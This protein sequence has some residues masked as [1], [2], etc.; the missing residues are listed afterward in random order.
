MPGGDLALSPGTPGH[1]W[2]RG[3]WGHLPD[4]PWA[5]AARMSRIRSEKG[6]KGFGILGGGLG[7]VWILLLKVSFCA[8]LLSCPH[9]APRT[10]GAFI[11]PERTKWHQAPWQPGSCHPWE[12]V[13]HLWLLSPLRGG[14]TPLAQAPAPHS[15]QWPPPPG[16]KDRHVPV[17]RTGDHPGGWREGQTGGWVGAQ[18]EKQMG[19]GQ[20]STHP[21][22]FPLALLAGLGQIP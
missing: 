11:G 14:T 22:W 3:S 2:Y 17:P 6:W 1:R 20:R 9:S 12:V 18:V 15:T 4:C 5:V 19:D 16:P 7:H 8:L 21:A 13:P 10:T